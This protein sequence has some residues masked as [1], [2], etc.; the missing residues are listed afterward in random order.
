MSALM[1][2]CCAMSLFLYYKR[3][4]K[5]WQIFGSVSLKGENMKVQSEC[6]NKE[7]ENFLLNRN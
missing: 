1:I 4:L 6:Y 2:T 7:K 5:L 3:C